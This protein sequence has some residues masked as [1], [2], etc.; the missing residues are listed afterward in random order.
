MGFPFILVSK[1]STCNAGDLGS[2]PG[3]GKFPGEGNGNLV[4]YSC[5]KNFMDRGAWWG[6]H[7]GLK[8]SDMTECLAHTHT[9]SDARKKK[10]ERF[11]HTISMY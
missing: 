8:E 2:I 10:R 11:L 5:L 6:V 3:L 4:Q 7:G 9:H 1:E